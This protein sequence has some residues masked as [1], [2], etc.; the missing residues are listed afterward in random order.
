MNP[1]TL[2]DHLTR[3]RRDLLTTL[4]ATPDGVLRA[5]LLRGERF[6][7]I[8][9]LLLHT[10]EVEDGWIHGD[11][12][13]LPM[14]QE[15]FPEVFSLPAGPGTT[16]SLSAIEAY[17]AAVELGTRAYLGDLQGA[18]LTRTVTLDDWPEGHRQFT[19]EGLIWHVLLH[20]VRHT[21][22]IAALLRTQG[23]KPPQLDLLFYLS[24]LET[25][26]SAAP[27][28]NPLPEDV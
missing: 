26:R 16:L 19:L 10:A 15:G 23:I 11:F 22:Q 25:G 13:G 7:S 21:A 6:H 8:L 14:L 28:V 1:A 27:V 5:P 3:A 12:Q 2:Y 17:W 9:D 4:R 20:E 18:D 24:A